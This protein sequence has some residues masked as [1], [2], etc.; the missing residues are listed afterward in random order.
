[1]DATEMT[2]SNHPNSGLRYNGRQIVLGHNS[3]LSLCSCGSRTAIATTAVPA[4]LRVVNKCKKDFELWREDSVYLQNFSS[5]LYPYLR[6]VEQLVRFADGSYGSDGEILAFERNDVDAPWSSREA[7]SEHERRNVL[8]DARESAD[9]AIATYGSKV[10][11]GNATAQGRVM[12]HT[13]VPAEHDGICHNDSVLDQTIVGHV[14]VGHEV[15]IAADRSN[16]FIFFGAS[17]DR[18]AFAKDVGIA[19]HDLCW[20]ALVGKVLRFTAND[21]AWEETII[22]A[23][24]RVTGQGDAV[25]QSRTP[26]NLDACTDDAMVP[27]TNIFVE[28]GS[29]IDHCGMGDY[30]WHEKVPER[31]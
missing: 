30:C 16:T 29:R 12:F 27:D 19:D 8:K 22:S 5:V 25:F 7:F 13:H 20:R 24:R 4:Q 17:I 23:D 9:K 14:G 6:S 15:A 26:A 2:T 11:H 1:M 18:Y 28:F 10:V 21:A 3:T 31:V